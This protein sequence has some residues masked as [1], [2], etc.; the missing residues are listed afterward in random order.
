M[1]KRE[2][3]KIQVHAAMQ[4]SEDLVAVVGRG[5]CRA[6]KSQKNCGLTSKRTADKTLLTKRNIKP[7]EKLAKVSATKKT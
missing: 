2:R 6:L 3:E 7:D 5:Q 4:V 1:A